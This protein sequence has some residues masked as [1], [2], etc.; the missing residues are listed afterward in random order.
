MQWRA[1][2]NPTYRVALR[3]PGGRFANV[4]ASEIASTV[5]AWLAELGVRS[6]L[7][8]DL[9]VAVETGDW[10]AVHAI[11]EYLSVDVTAT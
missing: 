5:S 7:V 6:P 9:A 4:P 1:M 10:S 2:A 11:A 8:D 3:V